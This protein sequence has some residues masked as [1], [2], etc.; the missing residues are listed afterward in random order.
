LYKSPIVGDPGNVAVIVV[1]LLYL[2][3]ILLLQYVKICPVLTACHAAPPDTVA[4]D[5]LPEP[6][7]FIT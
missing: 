1:D 5:K 7:V 6:S 4:K 3:N 2:Q